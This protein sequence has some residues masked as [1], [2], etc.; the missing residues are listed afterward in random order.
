MLFA[1]VRL[2]VAQDRIQHRIS[3]ELRK[4]QVFL[5]LI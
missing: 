5:F 3:L 1:K 2:I 4:K